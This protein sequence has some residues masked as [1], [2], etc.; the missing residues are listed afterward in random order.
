[1][2]IGLGALV[3]APRARDGFFVAGVGG[4]QSRGFA[5]ISDE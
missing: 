1:M 5:P 3:G 4:W 2:T